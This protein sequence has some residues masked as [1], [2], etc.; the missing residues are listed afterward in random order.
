MVA[1]GKLPGRQHADGLV[2]RT[3]QRRS[4]MA[5][6]CPQ[7]RQS[8]GSDGGSLQRGSGVSAGTRT[9]PR[10]ALSVAA[11][12]IRCVCLPAVLRSLIATLGQAVVA[13]DAG[14]P[15]PI[16]AEYAA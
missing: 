4:W 16:V 2:A 3:A 1:N 15:Q 14:H 13:A 5:K 12:S 6:G 10:A 8:A 11:A 9:K 7:Q